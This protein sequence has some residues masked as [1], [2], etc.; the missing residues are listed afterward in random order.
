MC[1]LYVPKAVALR[2]FNKCVWR[3]TQKDGWHQSSVESDSKADFLMAS[4]FTLVILWCQLPV[5]FC[6][7]AWTQTNLMSGIHVWWRRRARLQT[8]R[9]PSS[10]KMFS[11][12]IY[13]IHVGHLFWLQ[14]G[15]FHRKVRDSHAWFTHCTFNRKNNVYLQFSMQGHPHPA[16]PQ[17]DIT[18][19]T[20]SFLLQSLQVATRLELLLDPLYSCM[21]SLR[22]VCEMHES[23]TKQ[24][25]FK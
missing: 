19:I 8:T 14:N 1:W 21:V 23:K 12:R 6:Q 25:S 16:I 20:A 4:R 9:I 22:F 24:L 13:T 10:Q 17:C 3:R 15:E 11:H 7:A 18:F 2:I 5:G